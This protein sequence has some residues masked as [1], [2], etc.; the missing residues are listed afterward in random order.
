[1]SVGERLKEARSRQK[2]TAKELSML[3]GVPEKT[4][5]RIETGEVKDPRLSS[6]IPLLKHLDCSTDEVFFGLDDYTSLGN[7]KQAFLT[8]SGL[9]S[10]YLDVLM[11][12][13][14]ALSIKNTFESQVGE[15]MK[16]GH[17]TKID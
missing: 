8:A 7:L 6:V 13:I 14:H 10:E 2:L 15:A 17:Y 11:T 5:Y 12:V 4:I 1:M 9:P 16:N 3:S